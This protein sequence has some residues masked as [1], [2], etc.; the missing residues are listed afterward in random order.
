LIVHSSTLILVIFGSSLNNNQALPKSMVTL[1]NRH[2]S[3]LPN[4]GRRIPP[5]TPRTVHSAHQVD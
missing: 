1:P 4:D 3:A 2:R 5:L